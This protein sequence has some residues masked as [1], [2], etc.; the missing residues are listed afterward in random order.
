MQGLGTPLPV[1]AASPNDRVRAATELVGNRGN[2]LAQIGLQDDET[3]AED[4][5]R[6]RGKTQPVEFVPLGLRQLDAAPHSN[7]LQAVRP[8]QRKSSNDLRLNDSFCGS[9]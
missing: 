6:R 3:V 8:P 2:G 1:L 4:L 5:G 9:T 7:L